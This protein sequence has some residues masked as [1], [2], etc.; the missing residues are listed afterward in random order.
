MLCDAHCHPFDLLDYIDSY[1][2]ES[3]RKET[4]CAASSWNREQFEYHEGLA[5]KSKDSGQA[6]L[7]LCCAVHPQLP[8]FLLSGQNAGPEKQDPA[9]RIKNE[10]FPLLENLAAEKRLDA[11]GETGF[12]LFDSEYRQ[13]EAIQDE[14]FA[15][16]LELALKYGLPLVIHV[17]KAMHKIFVNARDLKKVRS[18]IF[19]S[20]PGT[21]GEAG[22]LLERGINVFFSFGTGIVNNHKRAQRCCAVLPADR[23][24]P[25]TDAPYL[26][27]KSK[28][29]SSWD[30]LPAI[31]D[32]MAELRK[33]AGS[34]VNDFDE[35]EVIC[36]EN[37]FRA[38]GL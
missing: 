27:L 1:K 36:A 17:R 8:L 30:D 37:F 10:F 7:V 33:E 26:P 2:L 28:K 20:W 5:K 21:E 25:E 22:S 29:F 31:Y 32:K 3:L 15:F 9:F 12:D 13:T 23:I 14:V 18:V 35:L 38:F 24:L 19:H 6:T 34:P 4:A 16:H 11:L